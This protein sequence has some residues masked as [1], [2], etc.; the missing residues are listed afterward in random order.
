MSV[1]TLP[2]PIKLKVPDMRFNH[3]FANSVQ[4]EMKRQGKEKMTYYILGKVIIKDIIIMPFLQNLLWT[5]ALITLK[6]PLRKMFAHIRNTMKPQ[7]K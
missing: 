7:R 1:N 6:E 2:E 4:R 5:G 3:I